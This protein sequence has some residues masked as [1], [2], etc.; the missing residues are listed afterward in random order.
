MHLVIIEAGRPPA[1]LRQAFGHYPSMFE[2]LL[3]SPPANSIQT[4]FSTVPI[5][6]ANTTDAARTM[7][8]DGLIRADAALITGSPAGVYEEHPWMPPLFDAI[9]DLAHRRVPTIGI[10]FGH[11]AIAQA[12]GG[13]VE[14]SS[15]GW[16]VGRHTYT[17]V[18]PPSWIGKTGDRFS[19]SVSHQD[20]VITP[21]PNA[22]TFAA[23]EHCAHA[24][25]NYESA[26]FM[27]FQGH[28]EFI[29]A[30][31]AAL[32]A[33]RRALIGEALC[34]AALESLSSCHAASSQDVAGWINRHYRTR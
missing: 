33:S 30:F 12:M 24:A 13:Q 15:K 1:G 21:P 5:C 25:L 7:L 22:H 16:G 34:D 32:Y 2:A 10:C 27:S 4:A 19:L 17:L 14:K 3:T 28:P 23:N 31:A 20:Q 8:V 29:D 9:R 11:Q 6:E 26:P 18:K